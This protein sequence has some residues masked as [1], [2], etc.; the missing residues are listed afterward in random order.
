MDWNKIE[1]NW[2]QSVALIQ[3]KWPEL[4]EY[5]VSS[6]D[7]NRKELTSK[8]AEA[9]EISFEKA[10][11]EINEWLSDETIEFKNQDEDE[12]DHEEKSLDQT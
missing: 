10:E 3:E 8:I 6:I 12:T 9:Y 1:G 4:K 2:K 7:G 11:S 5:D